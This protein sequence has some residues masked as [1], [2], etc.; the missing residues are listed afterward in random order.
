MIPIINLRIQRSILQYIC[1]FASFG[2][3]V[4]LIIHCSRFLRNDFLVLDKN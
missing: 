4:L 2:E 1:A 3:I